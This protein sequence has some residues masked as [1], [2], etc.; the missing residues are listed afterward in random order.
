MEIRMEIN[1]PEGFTETEKLLSKICENTF[2]NMWSFANPFNDHNKE[3]CDVIAIFENHMFIFFDRNK[4]LEFDAEQDFKVKWDRWVRHVIE[5]QIKTCHGAERYIKNGG[6]LFLDNK[7]KT[8]FPLKYDYEQIIIHKIIVAHGAKDACLKFS[9]ENIN[10]SLGIHYGIFTEDLKMPFYISLE[11]E[12]PVHVFDSHNLEII[13]NE[14]DTFEDFNNYIIEKERAVKDNLF[15][16]YCG[17]EDLLAH[18]LI[19][20]DQD[21]KK[22]FMGQKD[23]IGFVLDQGMWN[24]FTKSPAYKAQKEANKPS[25]FWDAL[26]NEIGTNALKGKLEGNGSVFVG[27][28]GIYEMAKEPR[29]IRRM[30]SEKMIDSINKFP[31]LPSPMGRTINVM[32]SYYKNVYY[33][34]L[35]Y[36]I[37]FKDGKKDS[38]ETKHLHWYFLDVACGAVKLNFPDAEKI[39]GIGMEPLKYYRKSRKN[40]MLLDCKYWDKE[41]ENYYKEENKFEYNNF[42]ITGNVNRSEIHVKEYPV[43]KL[44]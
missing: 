15:I 20:F 13:L 12:N 4:T 44:H 39:I 34:F 23:S 11:R 19:N 25:Y 32:S 14:L 33:I 30:L 10:G 27:N 6:K 42:L 16:C 22:H 8:D 26:I 28:S 7:L 9:N 3:F 1:K 17:E 18:Y 31:D 36:K 2:L 24:K 38:E 35:Q 29:F 5:A 41:K 43:S 37:D 21:N 40:I